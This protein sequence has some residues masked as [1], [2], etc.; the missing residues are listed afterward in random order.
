[1]TE[2]IHPFYRYFECPDCKEA[3][4][5]SIIELT[6]H[7]GKKKYTLHCSKCNKNYDLKV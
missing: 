3:K 5:K 4:E 1:M 2:N 6:V 7:S